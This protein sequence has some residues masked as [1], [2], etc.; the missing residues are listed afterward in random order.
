MVDRPNPVGHQLTRML[1]PRPLIAHV[2]FRLDYGGLENGVV[3]IVNG[4]AD[5]PFRHAIIALTQATEFKKRLR[6]GVPVYAIGKRPGKD[7]A[8]YWR[9][10]KL[11]R[12]LKPTAV[13]TRNIGTLDCALVA[14]LAG[15]PVRIHGEHGWDVF[16]PDGTN[17]KYRLMRVGL[18]RFV[19]RFVSRVRRPAALACGRG[20]D[21]AGQ[22]RADLQRRGH[23]PL[24]T[25]RAGR[26]ERAARPRFTRPAPSWSAASRA[27][28]RSRIR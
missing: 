7:P 10:F 15:V 8:A 14:A 11:L 18:A 6:D 16:D 24:P 13:H 25:A 1:D 26:G 5:G 19:Q 9:L 3:N 17:R 27:S 23:G 21:T 12:E 22:S 20:R 4:S 28:P 2:V